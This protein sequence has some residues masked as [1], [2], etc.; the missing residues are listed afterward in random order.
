MF[1]LFSYKSGNFDFEKFLPSLFCHY[2]ALS[3]ISSGFGVLFMILWLFPLVESV[4]TR[5]LAE[6]VRS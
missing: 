6:T 1:L 3:F 5:L 2:E 4:L